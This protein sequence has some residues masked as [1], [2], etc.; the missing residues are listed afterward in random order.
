MASEAA[1]VEGCVDGADAAAPPPANREVDVE[2][3]V[4]AVGALNR[5]EDAGVVV[6]V[7]VG[8]PPNTEL[9]PP[10]D[11]AGVCVSPGVKAVVLFVFGAP[12]RELPLVAEGAPPNNGFVVLALFCPNKLLPCCG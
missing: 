9:L 8:A 12:N 7:V 3:L 10:A 5:F 4:L 11:V 6:A 1:V 2:L